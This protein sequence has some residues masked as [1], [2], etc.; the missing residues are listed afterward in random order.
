MKLTTAKIYLTIAITSISLIGVVVIQYNWLDGALSLEQ[1]KFS[2]RV[3][4][5]FNEIEDEI[6]SDCALNSDLSKL[7]E[8]ACQDCGAYTSSLPDDHAQR[9]ADQVQNVIDSV[10][11]AQNF[12]HDY[13]LGIV[14]PTRHEPADS[15]L[16][17]TSASGLDPNV[18]ENPR[19]QSNR[20]ETL[21]LHFPGEQQFLTG[22]IMWLLGLSVMF[23]LILAACFGYVIVT[24]HR[25]KKLSE[26]KNDFINNLTH[27]F[28]TPIFSISVA[29]KLLGKSEEVGSSPKYSSYLNL[30]TNENKRLR[31][32]VDKVLQ[33]S[34][35]DSGNLNLTRKK[36]DLHTLIDQ[37]C[38]TFSVIL[39]EKG[40]KIH[41]QLDAENPVLYSDETHLANVLYN[42]IDNGIKYT[43]DKPE[44]TIA[45]SDADEGLCLRVKDN[46][47]GIDREAQK[48]IFD[49]FYRAQTGDVH[50]VKGFGLGLS[51]VKRIVDAHRGLIN[52]N[53]NKNDGTEFTITLPV[54]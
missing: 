47:I 31:A 33:M 14:M 38:D 8:N 27:E 30:I 42:L 10:F 28:K 21:A 53:S 26:M 41:K 45:T 44:I 5:L 22:Q 51:Y 43:A 49:K 40:G 11:T 16:V 52:L 50:D 17:Y 19:H 35:L 1:E 37:V 7:V 20:T 18:F 15:R 54:N 24:I 6:I 2:N 32:Q 29:T 34:L 23:I 12:S 4:T 3:D 48:H 46:G 39:E 36:V 13:E 9:T 25:Q